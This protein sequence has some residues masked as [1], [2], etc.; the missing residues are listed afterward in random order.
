MYYQ[1]GKRLT[2]AVADRKAITEWVG[3]YLVSGSAPF[4]LSG[5]I[6]AADYK[7]VIDY[8]TDVEL[9]DSRDLKDPAEM[10]KYNRETNAARNKEKGKKKVQTRFS[11]ACGAIKVGDT[12]TTKQLV[13]M[14]YTDDKARK[15][16]VDSGV[17]KRIKRGHYLVLPV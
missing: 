10:A 16:L 13:E 12:L 11:A 5:A 15:R 7:F 14:G 2:L 6:P 17:L 1:G 9:V 8:N 4:P 3:D